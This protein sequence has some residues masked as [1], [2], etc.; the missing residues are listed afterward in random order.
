MKTKALISFTVTAKLI[1]AF[2]FAYAK[3]LLSHDAAQKCLFSHDVAQI[4][5]WNG[6]THI[7]KNLLAGYPAI[8]YFD[9]PAKEVSILSH[10][11]GLVGKP[12][13][14]PRALTLT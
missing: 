4:L 1:C 2:V 8:D 7:K 3:C 10:R 11:S 13:S 14:S 9:L 5:S 12:T 6:Y